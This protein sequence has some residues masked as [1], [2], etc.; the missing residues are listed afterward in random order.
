MIEINP[1]YFVAVRREFLRRKTATA[2]QIKGFGAL[3]GNGL[4]HHIVIMNIV[5]PAHVGLAF[6]F[7]RLR[8]RNEQI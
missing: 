6:R 1:G 3:R 8:F 4:N 2:T 5:I 7:Y